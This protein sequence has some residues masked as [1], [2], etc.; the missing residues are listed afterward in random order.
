MELNRISNHFLAICCGALD[1]GAMNPFLWG[2]EEREK[3]L[4]LYELISGA[5]FHSSFFRPFGV[6]QILTRLY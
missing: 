1:L 2:F 4:E 6:M 3:L 5:R